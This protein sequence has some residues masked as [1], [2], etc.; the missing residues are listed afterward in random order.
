MGQPLA[1]LSDFG[2]RISFRLR[3]FGLRV[4]R[5]G[6]FLLACFLTFPAFAARQSELNLLPLPMKL[7]QQKGVFRLEATSRI[8]ADAT[9]EP[10]AQYLVERLRRSTGFPLPLGPL[11]EKNKPKQCIL[12]TTGEA[13]PS[14]GPEGYQ[15]DVAK[16]DV[17]IHAAGPA[18]LFYGVQ[19]LLQ[20]FPEEIFSRLPI[21]GKQWTLPCVRI[22][23]QPRFPWRGVLLDVARHFFTK[24]ELQEFID[25]VA[26]HKVNM[27]QLHL[28]DDQGWRVE[29]KKYPRLSLIGGWRKSIGFNLNPQ[30]STAYG[31]DGRYGGFYTQEDLRELI[32]YAQSRHITIVPE[33]EMPGHAGA[34]LAAYPQFSCS[35]APN[36]TD[37][38]ASGIYCPGNEETFSF[39]EAVL[40]EVCELFPGKY[41]HIGGDEVNKDNWHAC[42]R[43][44]DLMRREGLK[45]EQELQSY[46]VRRI[47]KILNSKGKTLIG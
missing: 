12:L 42:P 15:I 26:I 19:S 24:Q 31:P 16:G 9:A 13:N 3:G 45:T 36:S 43:C 17:T 6:A 14:L 23:D 1:R 25:A 34:A 4:S 18:G 33:I 28:T 20:L 8:L 46:F 29:I 47:E 5:S 27:L 10:A 38:S 30:S 41:V 11:A 40:T 32:A 21:E 39:L 7:E 44:Q 22:E 35:G 2:L 37:G